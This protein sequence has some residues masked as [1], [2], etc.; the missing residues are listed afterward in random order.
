MELRIV[1]TSHISRQSIQEIKKAV[2]ELTPDIIAVELDAGRAQALLQ[3]QKTS[4]SLAE[5]W[6]IG[7][8]GY[9]F[10]KFGQI[11]QQKLGKMV[12]VSP[13]E[14]M[15]TALKLAAER[16]IQVAL[17]DQPLP[18]TL[19][20][21]SKALT[22]REKGRFVWD[23]LKGMFFPRRQLREFGM[24]EFDL[25]NVPAPETIERLMLQLK[26]RYPSLY[27]VLV[28]ERNRYMVHRLV[29]LQRTHPGKK[30]LVIV[31]AGHKRGMEEMLLKVDIVK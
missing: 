6:R 9:L 2:A 30:M 3:E 14:E 13:G 26:K 11:L 1:G 20:K 18:V 24:E 29:Q 22:W 21:F 25:R 5:I 28:E 19:R 27:R 7:V 17:I 23:M 8:R 31:G 15:K 12:G 4:L 16:K 10:A